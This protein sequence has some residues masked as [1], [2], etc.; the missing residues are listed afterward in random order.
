MVSLRIVK[1][2]GKSRSHLFTYQDDVKVRF[3]ENVKGIYDCNTVFYERD[4]LPGGGF[5]QTN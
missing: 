3:Y 2:G 5:D 4:E 1:V